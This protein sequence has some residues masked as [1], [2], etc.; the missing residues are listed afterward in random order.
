MVVLRDVLLILIP[1]LLVGATFYF[2]LKTYLK[3]E[4]ERRANEYKTERQR[5]ITPL[6]LQAYE[7][8]VLLLERITPS[9]LIMRN[10]NLDMTALELQNALVSNIRQEFDHNLSQQLYISSN[11]WELVKN[12]R[13]ALISGINSAGSELKEDASATDLAQL[14]FEGELGSERSLIN[15]ALEYVKKEARENF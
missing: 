11:A 3:G 9:Q 4:A 2:L 12:A 13:E 15:K 6:R 14:I 1:A 8:I 7:R 5:L 10:I